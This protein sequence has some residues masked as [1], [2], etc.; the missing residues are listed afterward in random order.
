MR[1]NVEIGV[2]QPTLITAAFQDRMYLQRE[3]TKKKDFTFIFFFFPSK[4]S[5]FLVFFLH[6]F[7]TFQT[8]PSCHLPSSPSSSV[9]PPWHTSGSPR[10]DLRYKYRGFAHAPVASK[11]ERDTRAALFMDAIFAL[12]AG[13][14]ARVLERAAT[15]IPGCL[16]I[17]LWAPVIA[18]HLPSRYAYVS[19]HPPCRAPMPSLLSAWSDRRRTI[20]E[21]VICAAWTRGSATAAAEHG[22]CSRHTGDRSAPS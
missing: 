3:Q 21:S 6:P 7:C 2:R 18:G 11:D 13:P 9:L 12:A 4:L 16:Y 10:A 17:F 15:R 22:R 1:K 5:P 14:R 8:N 20:L 19:E